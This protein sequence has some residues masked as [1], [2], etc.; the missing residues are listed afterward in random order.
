MRNSNRK[1]VRLLIAPIS[2]FLLNVGLTA[3]GGK[4][5]GSESGSFVSDGN[6]HG[7]FKSIQLAKEESFSGLLK[8]T[9]VAI[10]FDPVNRKF[11]GR[12]RN[13]A[14]AAVCDVRASVLLDGAVTVN[15]TTSGVPY[16]LAGL[17]RD[18]RASFEFQ[19]SDASFNAWSFQVETFGCSSA[20]SGTKSRSGEGSGEHGDSGEGSGEGG[21]GEGSEGS[22]PIPITEP[23]SGTFQNQNFEFAYDAA[24]RAFR[25]TVENPTG[26]TICQ[27]RTEIHASAGNRVIELGPTIPV[28]LAPG[29]II[30]IV[31]SA[32]GHALDTYVLHP[33]SSPCQ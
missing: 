6:S 10:L 11:V 4:G 20:P 31:M 28:D 7:V 21:S 15:T 27:S 22:P 8:D 1:T 17:T 13:E 23:Y 32:P 24:N 25:G 19:V 26:L 2:M 29:D 30:K 5:L 18:G 16:N 12:L 3:C 33:E 9:E 14:A